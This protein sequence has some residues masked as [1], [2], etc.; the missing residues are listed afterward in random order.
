MFEEIFVKGNTI[1]T[2]RSAPLC[3]ERV[4]YLLHAAEGGASPTTLRTIARFQLKLVRLVDLHEGE[5]ATRA[6]ITRLIGAHF[7]PEGCS[8]NGAALTGQARVMLGYALQWLRFL[9][10]LDEPEEAAHPYAA[11]IEAFVV[12]MRDQRGLS[13][14]TIRGRCLAVV[15]FLNRVAVRNVPLATVEMT[16]VDEAI[17]AKVADGT[18]KRS[19]INN[20]VR[21]VRSFLRFAGDR[22]WCRP[23]LFNGLIPSRIHLDEAVPAGVSRDD[24]QRLLASTEGESPVDKRDRAILMLLIGYGLR[25]GEVCCLQLDDIDWERETL[26][27]RRSKSGRTDVYPLSPGVG[28]AILRYLIDVRPRRPERSLFL[29]VRAPFRPLQTTALSEVVGRRLDRLRIAVRRRGSHVFRH[30]AA[31]HLLDQGMA[32]KAVGDYL[33]HR[34]TT[35]TRVYA[36]TRIETLREVVADF[37]LEGLA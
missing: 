23:G 34:S 31:Q 29:T 1:E 14:G 12:W 33:G 21:Y 11:E 10:R 25:S 36:R 18:Y 13:E 15:D 32:M 2:Y 26:R 27:V 37:D 8:G 5:T 4:R 3:K 20:H 35:S 19:T 22:G 7:L 6:R 28:H 9:G 30:A 24:I 16:D 17:A